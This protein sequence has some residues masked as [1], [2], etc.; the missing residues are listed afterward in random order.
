MARF[1]G[2]CLCGE[3][4]FSLDGDSRMNLAC[5]CSDCTRYNGG[6]PAYEA[7]FERTAF[8]LTKG[9]P[10]AYAG[11]GDSG[12]GIVRHFCSD[13]GTPLY[14]ELEKLPRKGAYFLR[15]RAALA[16]L[17]AR[18]RQIPGRLSAHASQSI[19][20]SLIAEG[21]ADERQLEPQELPL[22]DRRRR[23]CP[24]HLGHA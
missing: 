13:C 5:H 18:R 16:S 21:L 8:A 4:R 1:E 22:R 17:R 20:I 6:A 7:V 19:L 2:G 14:V 10:R 3:I 23:H 24:S 12:R 11:K 9:A 15:L